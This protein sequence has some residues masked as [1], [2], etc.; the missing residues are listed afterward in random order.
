MNHQIMVNIALFVR[1]TQIINININ[2]TMKI[3][4]LKFLNSTKTQS[5]AAIDYILHY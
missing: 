4:K 5:I 3:E 1:L 2:K